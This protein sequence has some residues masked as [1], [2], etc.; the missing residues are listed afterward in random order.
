MRWIRFNNGCPGI[1]YSL[2]ATGPTSRIFRLP[3]LARIR[4]QLKHDLGAFPEGE[5]LK[6]YEEVFEG[7][8]FRILREYTNALFARESFKK[9][10]DEAALLAKYKERLGHIR[11]AKSASPP[12]SQAGST[13]PAIKAV[14]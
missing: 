9:T 13:P 7:E 11:R 3:F 6:L 8:R 1:V 12:P 2:V 10:F 14:S 5:G 4:L